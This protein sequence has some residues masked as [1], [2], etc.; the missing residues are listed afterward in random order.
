MLIQEKDTVYEYKEIPSSPPKS[1][2]NETLKAH[3]NS[4]RLLQIG[5]EGLKNSMIWST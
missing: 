3:H 1:V 4:V 5:F 2:H